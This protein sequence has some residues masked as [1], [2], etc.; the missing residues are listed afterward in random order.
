VMFTILTLLVLAT[1]SIQAAIQCQNEQGNHVDWW[2]IYKM[3]NGLKYAYYDSTS[4]AKTLSLASG[5]LDA[6]GSALG[7]TLAQMYSAKSTAARVLFNDEPAGSQAGQSGSGPT[8]GHTKGVIVADSSG[9]FWLVHSVPVFPDATA[10]KYTWK[11][12]ST[13]YG[14]SFLCVTLSK[15]G[16]EAAAAQMRYSDPFVYD[17]SVPSSLTG[18]YPT[19]TG[20]FK[21]TRQSG[22]N[23]ATITTAGGVKFTSFAK[24]NK[25]GQDLYDDLVEPYFKVPF[26]WET[27]RRS[28]YLSSLCASNKAS[29]VSYDT[30]NVNSIKLD[31]ESFSYTQ[32]HS[33]WGVSE[34]PSY[35]CVGGIN[36]MQSQRQR[37][38]DTICISKSSFW[39]ALSSTVAGTDPCS[40][41]KVK[42][43]K[44][45]NP[46]AWRA[47]M[48]MHGVGM[49][50]MAGMGMGHKS[51]G[52]G[53]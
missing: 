36:R 16:I 13:I 26:E 1:S 49:Q 48:G 30:L 52:R 45:G 38:G 46:S 22:S 31:T 37:G 39:N 43:V 41:S 19:L 34:Q 51:R 29:G 53:A 25:W 47:G 5:T 42:A 2:F 18:A 8:G 27:W 14:Q 9:G 17:S 15:S 23:I 21:G 12:A 40:G 11:G 3:P 20:L 4:S 44:S 50:G 32:D 7:Q 6:D 35:V 28:P 10:S 24:D 33:K